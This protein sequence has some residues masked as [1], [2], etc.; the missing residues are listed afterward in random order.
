MRMDAQTLGYYAQN[1]PD[2]LSRY[3]SVTNSLLP[4]V[5][6][7]FQKG[8][9]VLDIG[10]GSGRDLAAMAKMG[11]DCYGVDP[12]DSFVQA[13]QTLH[14]E[15]KDRVTVG[16][17]PKLSPPFGGQFDAVLCSAVLMHIEVR[18]LLPSALSIKKCLKPGGRLLYSVPSKRLDIVADQRDANGRLFV[19]GQ[20]DRLNAIVEQ[21]GFTLLFNTENLDSMGRSEVEWV[22]SMWQLN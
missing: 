7:G 4:I 14:P 22:S 9:K 10:C 5:E 6:S 21:L 8:G 15:L 11:F 13:S 19:S 12:T 16:G 1:A 2:V 20:S 18:H 17:L 3:E